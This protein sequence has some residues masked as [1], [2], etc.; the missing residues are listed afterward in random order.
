ME[1]PSSKM[2]SQVLQLQLML[3]ATTSSFMAVQLY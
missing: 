2:L 1:I 3:L